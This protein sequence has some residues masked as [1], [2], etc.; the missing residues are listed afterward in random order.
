[1]FNR[2][3]LTS[4]TSAL[5]GSGGKPGRCFASVT[6]PQADDTRALA[7]A[8]RTTRSTI[9]ALRTTMNREQTAHATANALRTAHTTAG[10]RR[11]WS[12][13]SRQ[14][15]TRRRRAAFTLTELLVTMGVL[16]VL[17]LLFTQLLNSAATTMTL[18]NKRMDADSQA[19]QLLDRMAI[20][21]DQML[22]RTDVSYYV[23]TIGNPQ[24]AATQGG[25]PNDRIAFFSAVPGY[26]SQDGYNSNASLVAYRVNADSSS[27]SYNKLERMGK[28]LALNGAYTTAPI[29]LLFLDGT[30]NT[31]IL[32]A[33]PAA[34]SSTT[35]DSD[36]ETAGSQVFR[37]EYYYLLNAPASA[38][39]ANALSNGA[40]A[41]QLSAGPWSNVDSFVIKD[42][43]S[44]VVA[45]A[46]I[47]PKSKVL[48]SNDQ[49]A[50]LAG[51]LPDF[52][53]GSAPGLL[54]AQWQAA[55]DLNTLGLPRP[56][57]SGIRLY[58]RYFYVK[59]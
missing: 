46:V 17:V 44:I 31:T 34:A 6:G 24:T 45:V 9:N 30:T 4:V 13:V 32:G 35:V 39:S 41:N 40:S 53:T 3:N 28:G 22:K 1:M 21:F 25:N 20:D 37:F 49:V 7:I 14:R 43:A 23:K 15:S 12:V 11:Q 2:A 55:L 58:E 50:A 51:T 54:L 59:Q 29:P 19:R 52:T 27:A 42:V 56:A 26:Y 36:Y 33:W 16:V 48:L 57:I 47:E 18:G 38:L 10:K 5:G 8:L